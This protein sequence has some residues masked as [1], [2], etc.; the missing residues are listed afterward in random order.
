MIANISPSSATYEDSHNTL[1][2]AFRAKKIKNRV[3][4]NT[5]QNN[6]QAGKY[7]QIISTLKDEITDLRTKLS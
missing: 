7:Q 5:L 1:L 2:Y 4:R 6:S 3:E